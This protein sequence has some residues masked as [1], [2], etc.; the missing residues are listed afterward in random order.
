MDD[1]TD[2]AMTE[3]VRRLQV[4]QGQVMLGGQPPQARVGKRGEGKGR[5][6]SFQLAQR[7]QDLPIVLAQLNQGGGGGGAL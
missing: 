1:D 5:I 4:D 3:V 6:A 2:G 7:G